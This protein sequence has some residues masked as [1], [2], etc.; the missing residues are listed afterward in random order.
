[1]TSDPAA[2][3]LYLNARYYWN[4]RTQT[5]LGKA[6]G[7]FEAATRQDPRYAAAYAGLASSRDLIQ[8]YAGTVPAQAIEG[9]NAALLKAFELD[10]ESSE[11]Y[12]TRATIHEHTDWDRHAAESDFRRAIELNPGDATAH[13]W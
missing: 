12:M 2:Y 6:A 1:S 13:A 11:A 10:P 5:A 8:E 7:Y 9:A 3:E 4:K